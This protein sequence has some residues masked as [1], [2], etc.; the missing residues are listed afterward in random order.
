MVLFI[1][2]YKVA[3]TFETVDEILSVTIRKTAI[4]QNLPLVLFIIL[5]N[6]VL[7]FECVEEM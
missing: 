2:L 7:S 5:C 6:V 1:V 4:E 3:L